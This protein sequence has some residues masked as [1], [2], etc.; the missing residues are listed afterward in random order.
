[1]LSRRDAPATAALC[2]ATGATR[3][4]P[5]ADARV[6]EPGRQAHPSARAEPCVLPEVVELGREAPERNAGGAPHGRGVA[7]PSIEHQ[8]GNRESSAGLRGG[9]QADGWI[10][11]LGPASGWQAVGPVRGRSRRGFSRLPTPVRWA[12]LPGLV[13]GR[14]PIRAESSPLGRPRP[15]DPS[16]RFQPV[17]LRRLTSC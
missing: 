17:K 9:K 4:P 1:L 6:Q 10:W 16:G 14:G 15:S 13:V 12:G 3:R 8:L 11:A 2:P 5:R 7:R